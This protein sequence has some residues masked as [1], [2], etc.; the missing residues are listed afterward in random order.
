MCIMW[1]CIHT[2]RMSK[3][4][5]CVCYNS[6]PRSKCLKYILVIL[7]DLYKFRNDMLYTNTCFN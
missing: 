2:E 4:R 1:Q 7:E 6:T 5:K 3:Q